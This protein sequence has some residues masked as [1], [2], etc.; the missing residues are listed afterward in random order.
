MHGVVAEVAPRV[1]DLQQHAV[2]EGLRRQRGRLSAGSA[3]AANKCGG[4]RAGSCALPHYSRLQ[5]LPPTCPPSSHARHPSLTCAE[6]EVPAAR[7]VT[8]T[9]CFCASG[10][11]RR[12]SSSL[13]TCVQRSKA[14]QLDDRLAPV[15]FGEPNRWCTASN[16]NGAPQATL[17]GLLPCWL[18]AANCLCSAVSHAALLPAQLPVAAA[19]R[20]TGSTRA[21]LDHHLGVEAVERGIGA[22][23][24]CADLQAAEEGVQ[25]VSVPAWC[26]G[27]GAAQA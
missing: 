22:V 10:R 4:V 27:V 9:W 7:K 17:G 8:G 21:H 26:L 2:G 1:A 12:I 3:Q 13:C 20:H 15:R 14:Q 18:P 11:M 6:S 24:K 16:R 25:Q 23:R 5:L 19:L